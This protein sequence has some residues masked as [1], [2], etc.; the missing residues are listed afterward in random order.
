MTDIIDFLTANSAT[1]VRAQRPQARD[2]AQYSFE[3]L[4]ESDNALPE[5][6]AVAAR[7][8]KLH[9]VAEDFYADLAADETV[10]DEAR[11]QAAFEFTDLLVAR[12]ADA[13]PEDVEK[14]GRHFD[15]TETVTL[16]Q[17]IACVA[18]QLRVIHGLNV[19]AGTADAVEAE[20]IG[21]AHTARKRFSTETLGW[22]P[23]VTP[24]KKSE[25]T[26]VHRD[27]LIKPEREN[28]PY[29]R[30][31]VRN[32][33][34]LKARTLTDLDIFYNTNGGLSRAEREISATLASR[35]NACPYCASVHQR[36]AKE[37]GADPKLLDEL[38][39][40][41]VDIDFGSSRLNTMRDAAIALTRTPVEFGAYHVEALRGE[42]FGD[43]ELLDFISAVA[44]F[45]WANRLMLSLG[46]ATY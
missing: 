2:N 24:L 13:Q 21:P 40:H 11:L 12:P 18:F 29:F 34:A 20:R 1:E 32:P 42:D 25:L 3:A 46:E 9:G 22:R 38:I 5:S 26:D 19:V 30:L 41:G 43:L 17:T 28:M 39:A 27:A 14:L 36:R 6:F 31:L 23:W 8:A 15:A 35:F 16:A 44:F 7:I 10:D 45:N 33:E 37:E 4:F